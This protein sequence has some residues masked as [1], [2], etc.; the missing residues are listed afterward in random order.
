MSTTQPA[1]TRR[2]NRTSIRS[3]TL[4]LA[5]QRAELATCTTLAMA[6]CVVESITDTQLQLR[7]L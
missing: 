3:L 4:R 2:P 7:A 1:T 5:A 6:R